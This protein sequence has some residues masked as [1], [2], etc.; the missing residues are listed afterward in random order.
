[1]T[2]Q[3][4]TA[5]TAERSQARAAG[6]LRSRGVRAGDRVALVGSHQVNFLNAALGALRVGIVPVFVKPQL[7]A[8]ERQM[9]LHDSQPALVM[10]DLDM[11][12]AA[13]WATMEELAPVPLSRPMLYTSG[14]TGRPKGVW[15]GVLAESDA[16]SLVDEEAEQW[17]FEAADI[18]LVVS[19]LTHS[20]PFRFAMGTLLAGGSV[21]LSGGV[22][23]APD[24]LAAFGVTSAFLAPAHLHRLMT[25]GRAIRT[26]RFR[27][28]AHAG[29]PCP[30]PVKRWALETF[31]DGSV[32]EF[33]GSTEGQISACSTEDYRAH[34]T[35]VGRARSGRSISIDTDDLIWCTVPDYARFSYWQDPERTAEAWSG[36]AFCIGDLGRLDDDGFLFLEGR[37][38]DL[39]ITGGVNVYPLEL[40]RVIAGCPGVEDVA[41]FGIDSERWG[42]QVC[43][44]VV[45]DVAEPAIRAWI[46][47]RLARFKH[48]K[49][50]I[51]VEALPHTPTGK[52]QRPK[53]G[54]HFGLE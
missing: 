19:E 41:V 16:R 38:N 8:P 30:E 50:I 13:A 20:A 32:W 36:P 14:T 27:M 26:D 1:M 15:T 39:I 7:T 52:L 40:E 53:L 6:W 31:P 29:A 5:E 37:R 2:V 45:G 33:Y 25:G 24:A 21:V 44:A 54:A 12:T 10:N 9:I 23:G 11:A 46:G 35:S 28:I 42:Q 22:A 4:L 51:A 18:H 34:P 3:L 48:P 17:G 49:E 47:D 43:A